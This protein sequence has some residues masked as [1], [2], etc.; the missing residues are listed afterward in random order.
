MNQETKAL[1]QTLTQLPGAPGN[2]HQVRAFMKQ[3]LAK[4]ADDIVQDRLG[5]VFGVRRGAEDAPRI[6]VAGHMDEVGFMVTSITDNGLLRF[7]TLGGWWSQVLLAQ[8]V[9]IQTDNGPV[10]G[11][12]SSIPPHLLTD[13]QRNR[14]MDIK[15]HDDRH[16]SG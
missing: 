8:R 2:E 1:F 4:Y 12:I 5:S 15:K 16:W 3:E 11:V 7:Q 14:P 10:P 13:A 9:E 6:M